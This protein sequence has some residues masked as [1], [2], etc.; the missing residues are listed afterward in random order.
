MS[1]YQL[2]ANGFPKVG[3]AHGH[4]LDSMLGAKFENGNIYILCRWHGIGVYSFESAQA[5]RAREPLKLLDFYESRIRIAD[6]SRPRQFAAAS[7]A[8]RGFGASPSAAASA[9]SYN[10]DNDNDNAKRYKNNGNTTAN[11]SSS[12]NSTATVKAEDNKQSV[13]VVPHARASAS[14][15]TVGAAVVGAAAAAA[16]SVHADVSS[17]SGARWLGDPQATHGS[18][19]LSPAVLL[20][21]K[22]Y[23]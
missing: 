6:S 2:D 19:A 4:K 20:A 22:A 18:A 5:L 13:G 14:S 7:S 12:N 3:F 21:T 11:N 16:T 15:A 17:P 1:G 23:L 10:N 8:S 9:M